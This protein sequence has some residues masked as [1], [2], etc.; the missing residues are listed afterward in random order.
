MVTEAITET[1]KTP[2]FTQLARSPLSQRHPLQKKL[3]PALSHFK[4]L[5]PGENS[6]TYQMLANHGH[7]MLYHML[8]LINHSHVEQRLPT[9]WKIDPHV[10]VRTQE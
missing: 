1:R 10:P 4:K 6:I 7:T 2:F 3:L 8:A 9:K 5:S